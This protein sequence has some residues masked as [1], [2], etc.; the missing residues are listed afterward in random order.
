MRASQTAILPEH[1]DESLIWRCTGEFAIMK[2]KVC[3]A[4]QT[5][6]A[7]YMRVPITV[8][9]PKRPFMSRG[10]MMRQSDLALVMATVALRMLPP[11]APFVHPPIAV[12]RTSCGLLLGNPL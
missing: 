10:P 7:P 2:I 3:L 8:A 6:P 4:S 9:A 11:A 1:A 5:C 12:E